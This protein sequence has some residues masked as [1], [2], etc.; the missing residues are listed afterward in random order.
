MS[1]TCANVGGV[2]TRHSYHSEIYTDHDRNK[3]AFFPGFLALSKP[4][5]PLN[6][7][8]IAARRSISFKNNARTEGGNVAS[9]NHDV[10]H[11]KRNTAVVE[12]PCDFVARILDLDKL[13]KLKNDKPEKK[14]LVGAS[15]S[16][17]FLKSKR[18][19][20]FSFDESSKSVSIAP[21]TP[22]R[23]RRNDSRAVT[24]RRVLTVGHKLPTTVGFVIK[25]LI[26]S[27]IHRRW[28][29]YFA[30]RRAIM[31]PKTTIT[32]KSNTDFCASF[33][34]IAYNNLEKCLY[35][36]FT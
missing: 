14:T 34:C 24:G 11:C 28:I 36:N 3:T 29:Y 31:L 13:K 35:T 18:R 17:Q 1:T 20:T 25:Y 33:L 10:T 4:R 8:P 23:K 5:S 15:G 26:M 27:K 19:V 6:K 21:P 32:N 30:C 7:K 9:T 2:T 22:E 12:K 16:S